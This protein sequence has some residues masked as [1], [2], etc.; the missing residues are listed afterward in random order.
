[1]SLAIQGQG[2]F[3]VTD[4]GGNEFFT[5]DGTFDM[6]KE[7]IVRTSGGLKLIDLGQNKGDVASIT[8][9]PDGSVLVRDTAGNELLKTQIELAI[10]PNPEA[11]SRIGNNLWAKNGSSGEPVYNN[12]GSEAFGTLRQH[13]LEQS[14]VNMVNEMIDMIRGQRAYEAGGKAINTADEMT[15]IIKK[16]KR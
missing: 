1:M 12:P 13:S 9:N 10:F 16:L 11:L 4:G 8:I 7:G 15:A 14:N 2:F 6:D 5:R 3:K